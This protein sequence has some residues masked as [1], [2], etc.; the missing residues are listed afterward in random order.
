MAVGGLV[1]VVVF[2][3]DIF[4]VA[5]LPADLLD[6]AIAGSENRCAVWRG[7]VDAGVHL[8]VAEDRMAA[9]AE[10]RAHDRVVDGFADQELLRALAGL[11]VI[12]D[13]GVVGGLE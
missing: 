4:A 8:D 6:D 12:V 3:A 5:A 9:S 10:A 1:A 11:V 2:Q 13:H 7:P